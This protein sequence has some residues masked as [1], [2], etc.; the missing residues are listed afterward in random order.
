MRKTAFFRI[1][2][3]SRFPLCASQMCITHHQPRLVTCLYFPR[4]FAQFFVKKQILPSTIPMEHFTKAKLT[5]IFREK[6]VGILRYS[7]SFPKKRPVFVQNCLSLFGQAQKNTQIPPQQYFFRYPMASNR[8]FCS[9][10]PN[11]RPHISLFPPYSRWILPRTGKCRYL[12]LP[13]S[14]AFPPVN[15]GQSA[16]FSP[17]VPPQRISQ[18]VILALCLANLLPPIRIFCR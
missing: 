16:P 4:Y 7:P 11:Q 1:Y 18:P 12:S 8:A 5:H 10:I 13:H 6:S 15:A 9:A 2:T 14:A 3:H 17:H